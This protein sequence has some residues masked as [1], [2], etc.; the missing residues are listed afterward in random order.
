MFFVSAGQWGHD[1][2]LRAYHTLPI[3]QA[4]RAAA[5]ARWL[6]VTPGTVADW[7]TGRRPPPRAACYALWLESAAGRE[8]MHDQLFNEARAHAGHARSLDDALRAQGV[9][10]AAL[11][12]E[13]D[14]VKRARPGAHLAANDGAFFDVPPPKPARYRV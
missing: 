14:M 10:L 4:A 6:D 7:I 2:F 3:P 12:V 13:L 9:T 1:A 5:I 11:R 8:V